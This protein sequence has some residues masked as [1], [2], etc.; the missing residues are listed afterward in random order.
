ISAPPT[1]FACSG[2]T[3]TPPSTA[4]NTEST[5]TCSTWRSFTSR[6]PAQVA[7]RE[8]SPP[9]ACPWESASCSRCSIALSSSSPASWRRILDCRLS[10]IGSRPWQRRRTFWRRGV[11]SRAPSSSTSLP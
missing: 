1:S 8:S 3:Q 4:E 9:A 10:T 2:K 6:S 5:R 11:A 7:I